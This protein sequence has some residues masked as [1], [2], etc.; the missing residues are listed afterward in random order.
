MLFLENLN[1]G[2]Y[3]NA[4]PHADLFWD[5]QPSDF[6]FYQLNC[7]WLAEPKFQNQNIEM[8]NKENTNAFELRL[9]AQHI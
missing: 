5:F 3:V 9:C 1:P 4:A 7:G 2:S 6:S 8:G